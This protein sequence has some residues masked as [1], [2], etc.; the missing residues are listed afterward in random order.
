MLVFK[1]HTNGNKNLHAIPIHVS[2]TLFNQIQ[3]E[4]T[5]QKESVGT[6]CIP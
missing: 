6:W 1:F 3:W 4:K 2:V 5:S